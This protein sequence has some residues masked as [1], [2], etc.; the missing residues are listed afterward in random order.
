VKRPV[1]GFIATVVALMIVFAP[2]P[3]RRD[4]QTNPQLD[5]T[6]RAGRVLAPAFDASDVRDP[7]FGKLIRD[8]GP[9]LLLAFIVAVAVATLPRG[10]FTCTESPP[11]FWLL[12]AVGSRGSRAPPSIL[13]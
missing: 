3:T 4:G 9:T 1:F 6:L 8:R 10:I 12:S 2:G 11:G 13:L 7:D 5:R